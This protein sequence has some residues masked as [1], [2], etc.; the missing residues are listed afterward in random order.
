MNDRNQRRRAA[1]A[2]VRMPHRA[3]SALVAF[4]LA[5]A[6][7]SL[8]AAAEPAVYPEPIRKTVIVDAPVSQVWN[9][10]TT[11]DGVPTF[12]GYQAEVDLRPGGVYR[13]VFKTGETDPLDRGNDGRVVAVDPGKMLSVTWMTPMFMSELRGNSTSLVLYF[14]PLCEGSK[15]RVD[16]VN[17]GYGSG[18][19]WLE[20]H[21]YNRKGWGT[22]LSRLVFRFR[23]GPIDWKT[24][25]EE[26][27]GPGD[28]LARYDYSPDQSSNEICP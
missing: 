8:A 4:A 25:K 18:S 26:P 27:R 15:T 16:L 23:H 14:S 9:A 7:S 2:T 20:A 21:A 6:H 5:A 22:V 1:W 17:T 10:W 11:S 24:F 28:A 13:V 19:R 3:R 12:M